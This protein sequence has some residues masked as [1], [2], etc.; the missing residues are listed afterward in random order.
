MT[1]ALLNLAANRIVQGLKRSAITKCSDWAE[2]YRTMGKPFPGPWTFDKFPWLREVHDIDEGRVTVQKAAQMGFTEFC[3]NRALYTIDI[4]DSGV[5]YLLPSQNPEAH[6]FSTSRFSPILEASQ[7]LQ[8]LFTDVKNIGHKR[9]GGANLFIRGSKSRGQVK[10]IPVSLIIGD[11]VDEMDQANLELALERVSGHEAK[12]VDL[13]ST[14]TILEEGINKFY[15]LGTMEHFFFRCPHCSKFI[16]LTWPEC[17]IITADEPTDPQIKKSYLICPECQHELKHE[18]K[19]IFLQDNEWVPQ[20]SDRLNR[21]FHINQL[22]SCAS[23]PWDLGEKWLR[24]LNSPTVETEFHNSKLGEVYEVEGARI[25]EDDLVDAMGQHCMVNEAPSG[26]FTVMGIDTGKWCHYEIDQIIFRKDEIFVKVLKIGKVRNFHDLDNLMRAFNC[27]FGVIDHQPE[28][29]LAHEFA[30]RFYG[31]VRLCH[32]DRSVTG[33]QIN[34]N[35]DE[36]KVN[37]HRTSWID[38]SLSR[39]KKKT[40]SLPMDTPLEYKQHMKNIVRVYKID[41]LGNPIGI[42]Q[43][44]DHLNDHFCHCR[45]YAEIAIDF[46]VSLAQSQDITEKY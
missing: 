41:A 31:S 27:L 10:S 22:Y 24:S 11:E 29:R 37:V 42:Y 32:Y 17:L 33:R 28:T 4:L 38:Q 16:E 39:I 44:P 19:P 7:H 5:L 20:K 36:L 14:P 21:S 23:K 15:L 40:I 26:A 6:D 46:A 30:Q 45:T 12:L 9:A 18:E 1:H 43:K 25:T 34:D 8:D 35:V 13:I 3:L 2:M